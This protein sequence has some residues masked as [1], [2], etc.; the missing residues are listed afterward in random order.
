MNV[1][2]VIPS[3][4][5]EKEIERTLWSLK[6]QLVEGDEIILVDAGSYDRTLE[7]A[8][9]H[10][11]RLFIY[12]GSKI[13]EAR[14]FGVSQAGN[15]IIVQT[16]TDVE[17]IPGFMDVLRNYFENNPELAG[18]S[19]GWRDGKGKYI[20]DVGCA[21][22]EGL[23]K[24]ADCFQSYRKSAYYQTSGHPAVSLGEQ[25]RLWHELKKIGPTLYDPELYVYHY[26]DAHA[27]YMSYIIGG[28]ILAG[29]AA[30][31]HGIGGSAGY[32]LIGHG[33]GWILGQAGVDLGIN[34]D[35]PPLHFHHWMLGLMILAGAM[36]FSDVLP[37]DVEVGLYGL[38]SGLFLHDLLTEPRNEA[39]P[40]AI[41]V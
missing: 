7:I 40:E 19:C 12:P 24:Y 21:M 30:Y 20:G 29:G 32:G 2:V 39:V 35:A 9:K 25:I 5:S 14:H 36:A 17:F 6:P 22:F 34:K 16:D 38:G 3:L 26:S 31:E 37:E 11:C 28:S 8:S 18:V 33:L 10:G 4:N 1:S 13:G 15:E 27:Q 41:L 23:F